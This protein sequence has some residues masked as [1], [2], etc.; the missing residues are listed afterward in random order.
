MGIILVQDK[1]QL[2]F[3][4]SGKEKILHLSE[5][6]WFPKCHSSTIQHQDKAGTSGNGASTAKPHQK[7]WEFPGDWGCS[8]IWVNNQTET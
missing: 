7:Q 5:F 3:P 8:Y 6:G 4:P 2:S 1:Y